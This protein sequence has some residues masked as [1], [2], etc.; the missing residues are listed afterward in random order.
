M[1]IKIKVEEEDPWVI[2]H[3]L[4]NILKPEISQK[5]KP[6]LKGKCAKCNHEIEI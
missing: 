5:Y 2:L 6:I 1:G 3:I 4:R